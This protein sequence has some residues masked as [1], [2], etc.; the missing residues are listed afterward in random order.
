[1]LSYCKQLSLIGFVILIVSFWGR[2]ATSFSRNEK[3][4]DVLITNARIIDGSGNPWFRADIGI[5]DG[6]IASIGRLAPANASKTIDAANLIVAPGFIDV[7]A[8]V[9]SIFSL[10]AAENF[11]RMG[12]TTLV[13][14]NCGGSTTDV[15]E[16]LGR[17]K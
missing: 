14:G 13:T 2:S 9:E 17:I 4:Y 16:F 3:S 8:H 7:H 15:T 11:V 12:V 5:K 1:M 10:P 6:R